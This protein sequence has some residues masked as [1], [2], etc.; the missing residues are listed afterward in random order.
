L[1]AESTLAAWEGDKSRAWSLA[2]SASALAMQAGLT[3]GMS[4]TNWRLA[5][6]AV[7]LEALDEALAYL[8]HASETYTDPSMEGLFHKM[9]LLLEHQIELERQSRSQYESYLETVH[10]RQSNYASL[11]Q[12]LASP[13]P[14]LQEVF[15][16]RGWSKTPLMLK[17]SA[18]LQLPE[19]LDVRMKPKLLTRLLQAL[20]FGQFEEVSSD[21]GGLFGPIRASISPNEN[22]LPNQFEQVQPL[23]LPVAFEPVSDIASSTRPDKTSN[24]FLSSHPS[25]SLLPFIDKASLTSHLNKNER[26]SDQDLYSL[27][28]YCLGP[29]RVY[30]QDKEIT[31]WSSFKGRDIFKYLAAHPET[32]VAKDILIDTFWRDADPKAARRNLHQAIYSLRQALKGEQPEFHHIWFENDCYSLNPQMDIWLDY[33]AFEQCIRVGVQ[34]ERIGHIERAIEQYETAEQLYQGDFFEEDLY[35]DWPII[36]RQNLLNNYLSVVDKLIQSYLQKQ[37]YAAAVPLCQKVLVKDRTNETA[38]RRLMQC[39]LAQGLRHLAVRQYQ[40]CLRALK[41]ELEID[42]SEETVSLFLRIVSKSTS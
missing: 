6:L 42:P 39:Y 11:K 1:L 9:V 35:E 2:Q 12:L 30:Q 38:H 10:A 17:M 24:E 31:E 4:D 18:P 34:L 26:K 20:S 37:Q 21:I 16:R 32:P 3:D 15:A 13:T 27:I 14:N 33:K 8:V 19:D 41:E 36:Q 40:T 22:V 25:G 28:V 7:A 23:S 5:S 29:F